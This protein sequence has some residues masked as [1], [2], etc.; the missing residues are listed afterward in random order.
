MATIHHLSEETKQAIA[1]LLDQD[2]ASHIL[3]QKLPQ[4]YGDLVQI[5]D[6]KLRTHKEHFG[7]MGA[8][9]VVEYQLK[10]SDRQGREKRLGIF[11]SA[12]SDGSSQGA[13]H[14]NK[15]LYEQG[16]STGQF[17]VTRPLFYLREQCA[18]FY[19][20]SP[21]HRLVSF[22]KKDPQAD[23]E[24]V[25]GLVAG[26]MK[27]LH[28]LDYSQ[29]SFPWPIFSI[30]QMIPRPKDFL[31][32]FY[33]ENEQL[34]QVGQSIY[35]EMLGLEKTQT[36]KIKKTLI[37]GDNHPENVIIQGVT[38]KHLEMIDFTDVA[39][40]DPLT[41]LGTF[42]QQFDFMAHHHLSRQQINRYK[43][44]LVADYFGQAF[45]EI[46]QDYISRINLYQSWTALRSATFL[47][48]MKDVDK[49]VINLLEDCR[50]YL[51]L[52]QSG[53]KNVNLF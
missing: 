34:G 37:Y 11:S 14:K 7:A 1:R 52:A 21:G 8:V 15:Y 6:I 49:S 30:A 51:A 43:L 45:P 36:G 4:H 18:Y 32:D 46:G 12:H 39:L 2:F 28:N 35:E 40:G 44:S 47:F 38:T 9:L 5:T 22:I 31:A 42:L 24:P 50:R 53:E 3:Q 19:Q 25:L 27:K 33:E 16:F 10:Y 13:Y 26:W 29:S 48:Y 20:A 23:L 17:R 41:D